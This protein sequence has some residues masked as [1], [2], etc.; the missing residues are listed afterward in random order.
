MTD[1]DDLPGCQAIIE[2]IERRWAKSDQEI[3]IAAMILN[4]F[5]RHEPL[6]ATALFNNAG[7]LALL[8]R[9]FKRVYKTATV[10]QEFYIEVSNYLNLQNTFSNLT[11][12]LHIEKNLAVSSVRFC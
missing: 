7:I 4:P 3:F 2:S 9:I 5:Y 10:P 12:Q 6:K 8:T 11:L 1:P